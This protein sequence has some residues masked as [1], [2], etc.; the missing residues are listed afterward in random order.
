M[1]PNLLPFALLPLLALSAVPAAQKAALVD[2]Y[3]AT[4][5]ANWVTTPFPPW[6]LADDP[7]EADWFGVE[8]D[9]A[10]AFVMYVRDL[11][12]CTCIYS[13]GGPIWPEH[14]SLAW[15]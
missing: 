2:L 6:S 13:D 4:G 12:R 7:C 5:G 3:G 8:C 14:P 11:G 10:D 15:C 9:N 1:L